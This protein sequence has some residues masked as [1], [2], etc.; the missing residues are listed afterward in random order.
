[1]QTLI[2]T[3]Q[4]IRERV[5]ANEFVE[6][7]RLFD[8]LQAQWHQAPPGECPAYLEA[9]QGYMLDWDTQ[10]GK[11]L[12]H[13]LKAWIDA[14]PKAY[15][16]HVVMGFHCFS[17]ACQIRGQAGSHEVSEERWLAA[18]QAC[19]KGAAHFLRAMEHGAQPVAAVIGMLLISS[20]LRE[21]GWLLELFDGQVARYRPSAHA[22]VEVQEAAAPLLVKFGL[23][24][25]LE[26]PQ[27][28]PARLSA[29]LH[30][31]GES[32]R[33]Y[34]LRHALAW[35][36]G[37][38]EAIEAYAACL[39]PRWGGSDEAIDA[40]VRGPSCQGWPEAQ[41]NAI[42]WLA[43]E[44]TFWLPHA[45][46]L[47]QVAAWQRTFAQWAQCEL[48]P[49][50]RATLLARRG[51]LRRYS[52]RDYAGAMRDFADSVAL[53]PDHGFVP[54]IGEPFHSLVCL[55]L[56]NEAEDDSQVLR[57]V[58]ERLCDDR[59][60]A[61]ACA[62]RAAGHQFGLWGFGP[63]DEQARLWLRMA[64]KRQCGR[65][66][67]GF[68]V[69]DVPRLLW[70][71]NLHEAAHFL[72]EACA[73]QKLP[74]AAIALYD[75]HRGWLDNTPAHYL[76]GKAA[77]HWLLRAAESGHPLAKFDLARQRMS[78]P[79]GLEDRKAVLA[80]KRL[81]LD[82]LGDPNIHAK[83]QLQ[84]GILLR[85]YGD[86]RERVEAVDYLLGLAEH[87]DAWTAARACA[88]LGL[89]WMQGSGT[90]KQS[91]FAAIEWASR[92]VALQ[93]SDPLIEEIQAE[94]R[95]SHSR[96]KTLFTVCGAALFRGDLHAS[97]LPPKATGHHRASA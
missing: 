33:D 32:A 83:A 16:P 47:P 42:R 13:T 61:A 57:T 66:G 35:F 15:H 1:M 44:E 73:E 36:P 6:L 58:I 38:F 37:C 78:A 29:R 3:R 23:T 90:R 12:T 22:D 52:M 85:Q 43:L 8:A 65:E 19:E 71:A 70:A 82:A 95:N 18:E 20:Q 51:A 41:R 49:K 80:V 87:P 96:V 94:I 72:Y 84:L 17:H 93:S 39:T 48:R 4:Q 45:K 69:L 63:S 2:R 9:L 55:V 75:L 97:E 60:Q 50:E 14:C 59:R 62:L 30:E 25:L 56:F 89:A 26:L 68:D 34:W 21:P 67:Q 46:Q 24:P 88:E 54:A 28:L 64:V 40:L 53:Y 79:Q 7:N 76:S 91:R 92:A 5:Q 74:G 31:Q 27:T 11:S 86:A 81:L 77:E 10:G